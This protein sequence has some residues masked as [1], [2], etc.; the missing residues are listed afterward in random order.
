MKKSALKGFTLIELLIVIAIVGVL[1]AVVLV[2]LNPVER[3]KQARDSGRKSDIGQIATALESYF[4][5]NTQARY[6]T[7]GG[8]GLSGGLTELTLTDLRRLPT[9]PSNGTYYY[10]VVPASGS[11][12]AQTVAIYST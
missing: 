12:T 9:D 7:L 3:L 4:T 5:S 6:P 11:L 2:A 1:A 8:P 10:T